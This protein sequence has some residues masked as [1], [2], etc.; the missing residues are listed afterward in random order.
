MKKT[1]VLLGLI[2]WFPLF[3]QSSKTISYPPVDPRNNRIV[4]DRII[5]KQS[6]LW[7][8]VGNKLAD[9]RLPANEPP[10]A[11]LEV[12]T[13]G[14]KSVLCAAYHNENGLPPL[15]GARNGDFLKYVVIWNHPDLHKFTTGQRLG[16]CLAVKVENFRTNGVSYEAYDCG[17]PDTVENRQAAGISVI[18]PEQAAAI[19]KEQKEKDDKLAVAKRQEVDARALKWN[20]EQADRG[21]SFG[22][23]RMGERYRDGEGV[24]KDLTKAKAYFEKAVVAGSGVA[25]SAL[26]K[27]EGEVSSSAKP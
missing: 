23:L 20:K 22:L 10:Y 17:L 7:V 12:E 18:T 11:N 5:P 25:K 14:K 6:P 21:D 27:L 3:A 15:A 26:L 1:L 13:I 19:R 4:G 9:M 8:E 24:E 16:P 2:A